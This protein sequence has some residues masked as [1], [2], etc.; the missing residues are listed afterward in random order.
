MKRLHSFAILIFVTFF[1]LTL[2]VLCDRPFPSSKTTTT[3]AQTVITT[4]GP[5]GKIPTQGEIGD[6]EATVAASKEAA[7]EIEQKAQKDIL[8]RKNNRKPYDELITNTVDIYAFMNKYNANPFG[9]DAGGWA[10]K[11]E[12]DDS[13]YLGLGNPSTSPDMWRG[14]KYP[15]SAGTEYFAVHYDLEEVLG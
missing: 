4:L 9:V 1:I 14:D 3:Q 2:T 13:E 12:Q 11:A 7:T 8:S 5:D 6:W 15:A 10:G